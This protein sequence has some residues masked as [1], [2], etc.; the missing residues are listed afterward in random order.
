MIPIVLLVLIIF[1]VFAKIGRPLFVKAEQK[2][3][4][5]NSFVQQNI[6]GIRVVK[7]FSNARYEIQ[8]FKHR[9]DELYSINVYAGK[10]FAVIIPVIFLISN[11]ST[12]LVVWAGGHQ[13]LSGYLTIG[14]LVA[15]QSYLMITFFPILML[16]MVIM[17][18]SQAG[19]G[20]KRIFEVPDADIEVKDTPGA[21]EL[22]SMRG[23]VTFENV[24]FRYF[25]G[26]AYVLKDVSFHID[27]GSHVAIVGA[28]GSGK[29]TIINL[30]PRFY[31]ATSGKVVIDG[32]NV[33]Y[34]LLESLRRNIGIV[35]QDTYLFTG[36]VRDNIAY[37]DPDATDEAV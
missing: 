8:R 28:T 23:S 24:S 3:G 7:A 9:N 26:G 29:S 22:E 13:V 6:L 30:I 4:E 10:I 15:F 11:I 1:G 12:L 21:K 16:G 36:T 20:A 37:G 27:A 18:V 5:L 19:A 32:N 34:V 35:L 17:S 25:E 2:L 33:K 31:D 14:E